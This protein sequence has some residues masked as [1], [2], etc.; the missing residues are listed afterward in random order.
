M[1]TCRTSPSPAW[2]PFTSSQSA[3]LGERLRRKGLH[4]RER[5]ERVPGTVSPGVRGQRSTTEEVCQV[6][7]GADKPM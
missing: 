4:D 6:L 2:I 1:N 3:A 7:S 5:K